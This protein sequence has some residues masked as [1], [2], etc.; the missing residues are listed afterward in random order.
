[1]V[2]KNPL[3]LAIDQ[4]IPETGL[5]KKSG[6]WYLRQ[7]ET[8]GV[9]NLQKSQYG[10]Q[11]YVN[12]AVWLLPLGDVDFPAEHKCHIRT[13]LTRLLAERE[14]ELVQVLDLTVER[15]DREEVLK[16]AIEENIVPIFKSCATLAGFRQ[17]QGRYFLECSLVVGEAQQLLDAVV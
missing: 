1:M 6:S 12:I 2:T 13:R 17:P 9:I 3:R 10:D 14:Q 7:E 5:V 15:P 8:I 11:Y 4:V 16:Q